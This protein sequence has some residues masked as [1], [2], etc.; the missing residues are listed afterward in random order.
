MMNRRILYLHQFASR[1]LCG[2][3]MSFPIFMI[4]FLALQVLQHSVIRTVSMSI[5]G[6][7][8]TYV[9][10]VLIFYI[11]WIVSI[12]DVY[13]LLWNASFAS[14]LFLMRYIYCFPDPQ[15]KKALQHYGPLFLP[16]R[17]KQ[18]LTGCMVTLHL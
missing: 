11:L 6:I 10:L 2:Y 5:F 14:N 18:I 13:S 1:D 16:H 12:M 3:R 4:S 9:S 17:S 8:G 7:K 15:K